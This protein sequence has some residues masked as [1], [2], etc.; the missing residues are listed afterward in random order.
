AHL[1]AFLSFPT[2]RSS[3]L[4]FDDLLEVVEDEQQ[5][6]L[7][8]VAREPLPSPEDTADLLRHKLRVV[9][10]RQLDP[11]DARAELRHE[12]GSRATSRSEEHTSELQSRGHLVC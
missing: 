2:R 10:R 11:E 4:R 8:D 7:A 6:T 12:R 3:D 1:R 9:E 5:L